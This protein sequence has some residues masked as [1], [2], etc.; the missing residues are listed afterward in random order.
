MVIRSI[1]ILPKFFL[2]IKYQIKLTTFCF[3]IYKPKCFT[4]TITQKH[5]PQLLFLLFQL[6]KVQSADY[7][8][9]LSD[10]QEDDNLGYSRN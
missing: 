1:Q 8:G 10:L 6:K 4:V 2:Q 5:K 9:K 7:Y 3:K